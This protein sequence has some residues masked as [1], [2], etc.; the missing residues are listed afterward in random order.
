MRTNTQSS[1]N[2]Q[3]LHANWSL[4]GCW[5]QNWLLGAAFQSQRS[6]VLDLGGGVRITLWVSTAVKIS[7]PPWTWG[8]GVWG[9][10]VLDDPG[11][12]GGG[13]ALSIPRKVT[14]SLIAHCLPPRV[15]AQTE[16]VRKILCANFW[17]ESLR[18]RRLWHQP[19]WQPPPSFIIFLVRGGGGF[20]APLPSHFLMQP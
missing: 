14:L 9:M 7:P 5:H 12:G 13:G 4:S 1:P 10:D 3:P 18:C 15:L 11:G 19:S 20:W 16:N 2:Y 17:Q 6:K 8:G